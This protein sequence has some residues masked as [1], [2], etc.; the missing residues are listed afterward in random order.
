MVSFP[1][2]KKKVFK[3]KDVEE[4]RDGGEDSLPFPVAQQATWS[5]FLFPICLIYYL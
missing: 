1:L 2:G 5:D 4:H 3:V